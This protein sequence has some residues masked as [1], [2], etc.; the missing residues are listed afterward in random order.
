MHFLPGKHFV[1]VG[2]L[3]NIATLASVSSLNVVTVLVITLN[4][5][6]YSFE[7]NMSTHYM[8]SQ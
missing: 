7:G 4:P 2:S 1:R 8:D 5:D 3:T 6:K